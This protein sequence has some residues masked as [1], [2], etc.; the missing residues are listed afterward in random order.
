MH[1]GSIASLA[2]VV[3]YYDRG[4][5]KNATLDPELRP[6]ELSAIEKQQLIAF[7]QTLSGASLK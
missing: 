1:D 2:A 3:D 4:G 7:L 5:N 6:L